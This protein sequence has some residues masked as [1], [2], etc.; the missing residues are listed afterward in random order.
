MQRIKTQKGFTLIEL[1]VVVAIVAILATIAV[2]S[3]NNSTV[4]AHRAAAVSYML[5]VANMQERYLLDNR[6]YAPDMATLGAIPPAEVSDFYTITTA[7]DNGASTVP[8]YYVRAVP[9]GSQAT[10]D[11]EC[12]TL[13][14]DNLGNRTDAGGSRCWR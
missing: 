8:S 3:Y 6:D 5:E 2:G 11:T 7:D 10:S 1:M 14:L 9:K 4:R 12:G 13:E